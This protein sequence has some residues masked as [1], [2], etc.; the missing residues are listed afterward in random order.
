VLINPHSASTVDTE[1]AKL[2]ARFIENLRAYLD[3]RTGDMGP[4]LDKQR[5]Y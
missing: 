1:N 5:L 3:G 4:V 2:T